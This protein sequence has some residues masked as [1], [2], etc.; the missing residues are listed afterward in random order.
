MK[1][2]TPITVIFLATALSAQESELPT[3]EIEPA[4]DPISAEVFADDMVAPDT[5]L[6]DS[7]SFELP[8]EPVHEAPLDEQTVPVAA[9]IIDEETVD[10]AI[11][12]EETVD[13]TAEQEAAEVMTVQ[14]PPGTTEEEEL[15]IQYDR[16]L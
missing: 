3:L 11:V 16:Y 6:E 14:F 15:V 13:E 7:D 1:K 2:L 5:A 8:S 4:I 12:D 9:D 10:E